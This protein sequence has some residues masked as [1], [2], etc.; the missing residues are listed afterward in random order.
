VRG[1]PHID[2]GPQNVL[3]AGEKIASE[4]NG[5]RLV[6]VSAAEATQDSRNFPRPPLDIEVTHSLSGLDPRFSARSSARV[7]H[8][9]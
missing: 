9:P 3:V 5:G 7:L 1:R 4:I 2:A 8:N 6:A